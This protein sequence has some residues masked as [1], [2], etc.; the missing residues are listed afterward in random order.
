MN[1]IL[2]NT[3]LSIATCAVVFSLQGCGEDR[4]GITPDE[5]QTLSTSSLGTDSTIPNDSDNDWIPD[6]EEAQ[7]GTDINNPDSDNDGIKDGCEVGLDPACVDTP[8]Q[9]GKPTVADSD[10]DGLLDGDE[11]ADISPLTDQSSFIT[12]PR[13]FDSDGDTLGDGDEVTSKGTDPTNPDTDSDGLRDDTEV[14]NTTT[15]ATDPDSDDDGLS[16]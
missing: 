12:D 2:K 13:V 8:S 15:S 6:D 3:I 1:K 14:K 4:A 16:E 5:A 7:Y 11:V 10:G 9:T